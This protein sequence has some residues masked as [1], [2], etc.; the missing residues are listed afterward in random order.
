MGRERGR[1]KDTV[2][3]GDRGVGHER[4]KA[5]GKKREKVKQ[6]KRY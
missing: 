5:K 6:G 4:W 3:K 2:I 1:R